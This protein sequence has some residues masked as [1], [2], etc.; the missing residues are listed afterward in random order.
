MDDPRFPLAVKPEAEAGGRF[1]DQLRASEL[2]W[3]FLSPSRLFA[4]GERTGKFRLGK[5][6]LLVD[7]TGRSAISMED[8]AIALVDELERP[9]HV[10]A[11]FTVGY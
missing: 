6:Q 1:L 4:P 9:A 5:D 2:E 7:H 8:Y 10:C 3:T 11:R